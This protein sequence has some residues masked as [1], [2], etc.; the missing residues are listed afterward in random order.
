MELLVFFG[1]L[2]FPVVIYGLNAMGV[3]SK[4][5]SDAA[6]GLGCILVG[7]CFL[8]FC[9]AIFLESG[10]TVNPSKYGPVTVLA[11]EGVFGRLMAAAFCLF[12]GGC[13]ISAGWGLLRKKRDEQ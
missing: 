12:L 2:A 13:V 6:L 7:V 11:G 4:A 3:L 10:Q 8:L 5:V 9:T 1:L